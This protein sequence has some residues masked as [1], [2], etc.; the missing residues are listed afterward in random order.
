MRSE[1]LRQ[2]RS[3]PGYY[4][5]AGC[6]L[7][8]HRREVAVDHIIPCGSIDSLDAYKARLFCQP[9]QLQILC[10]D[11][12]HKEKTALERKARKPK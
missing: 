5:C 4:L 7:V 10:K 9:D 8:F 6:K 12:C 11:K 3:R 1:A 2:A